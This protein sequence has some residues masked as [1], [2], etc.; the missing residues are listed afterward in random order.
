MKV[1]YLFFDKSYHTN[2]RKVQRFKFYGTVHYP[3]KNLFDIDVQPNCSI[4]SL[5]SPTHTFLE[6]IYRELWDAALLF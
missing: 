4:C 5:V 3:R 6:T 2:K 1:V